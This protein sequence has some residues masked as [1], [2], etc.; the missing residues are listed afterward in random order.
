MIMQ[1]TKEKSK[2]YATTVLQCLST[3]QHLHRGRRAVRRWSSTREAGLRPEEARGDPSGGAGGFGS[4]RRCL[5]RVAGLAGFLQGKLEADEV[6]E[7]TAVL[8]LSWATFLVVQW[9]SG[10]RSGGRS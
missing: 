4:D 8:G 9:S 7:A 2:L 6:Q 10:S 5:V 3:L 1:S